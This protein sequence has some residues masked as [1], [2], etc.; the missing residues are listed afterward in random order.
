[1][2]SENSSPGIVQITS[3]LLFAVLVGYLV[4]VGKALLLPI[5]VGVIS[6]YILT[7]S[8][9]RL[10]RLPVIGGLPA[11][12]RLLLAG[13]LFLAVVIA[14]VLIVASNTQA[15]S[16]AVPRYSDNL[17]ALINRISGM[18]GISNKPDI[19][20]VFEKIQDWLNIE[21][22]VN[23]MLS[24]LTSFGTFLF[25]A[26]LYA[27]FLLADW[28]DLPDKTRRAFGEGQNAERVVKTARVINERIGSYLASKTLINLIL[29]G[30][31][32]VVMW[33]LGIEFAFFWAVLIALL[34]YIPYIGSIVGVL[35]PVA[36]ALAQ[37]GTIYNPLIAF[38][39]LMGAQL[40]VGNYLEPKMLGKSVNMSPF[41][42][43]I[44]LSFWMTVWGLEGA[45]LAIPLTSMI[46]IVLAEIP[47]TR[48][49]AALMSND[50]NI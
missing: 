19:A 16:D 41:V 50:G 2:A 21:T 49:L 6:A 24:G 20:T 17:T 29:G 44:A 4:V 42:F 23:S 25:S 1:M 45:I 10:E 7:T 48:P 43:L 35:F 34:N 32:L 31:S 47:Q 22:V 28:R 36:L 38:V 30:I 9:H 18:L 37:F 12:M 46:M 15:I 39:A 11:G 13:L 26:L 40:F 14:F 27:V 3:G 8:A 5:L 33:V